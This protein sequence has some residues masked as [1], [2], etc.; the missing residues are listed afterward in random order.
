MNKFFVNIKVD[1]EERPD[2]DKVRKER[3]NLKKEREK[4]KKRTSMIVLTDLHD[5]RS[6]NNR[7]R[8]MAHVGV[9]F[10]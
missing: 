2:I 1:R 8:R 10:T 7:R 4:I 6:S 9:Y 3:K 5:I